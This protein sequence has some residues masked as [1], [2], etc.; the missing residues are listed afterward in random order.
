MSRKA[1]VLK[2]SSRSEVIRGLASSSCSNVCGRDYPSGRFVAS[3][4]TDSWQTKVR[5]QPITATIPS[6]E[7]EEQISP[8]P[9]KG[10][11]AAVAD[12]ICREDFLHGLSGR[13]IADS[14]EFRES[15]FF[16]DE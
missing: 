15:A 10:K 5:M 7:R 6:G 8:P 3:R 4:E 13:V 11:W 16:R 14:K 1:V 9:S 2:K 12:R